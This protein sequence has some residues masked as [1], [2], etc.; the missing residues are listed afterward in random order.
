[1]KIEELKI[2]AGRL[3]EHPQDHGWR[4]F[5]RLIKY[6]LDHSC[7]ELNRLLM[8][9]AER[10]P[11]HSPSHLINLLGISLKR[12]RPDA[13]VEINQSPSQKVRLQAL[14]RLLREHAED[15]TQIVVERHNSF[16]AARRFLVPQVIL[17]SYFAQH[18]VSDL[19]FVDFGTGLGIM[20]RQLNSE[21]LYRAFSAD[22]SWPEGVPRFREIPL[23]RAMGVDCGPMPD[24]EWV[25]ACYGASTYY[26]DLFDELMFTLEVL[27]EDHAPVEYREIDLLNTEALSRFLREHPIHAGNLSYVLYEIDPEH[28]E[29]VL[30][31]LREGLRAP[32]LII[33]TEPHAE[34]TQQGC[35]VMAY[36]HDRTSPYRL[37]AVSDGHFKGEV[38]AL[39]DYA[40]FTARYPIL[41]A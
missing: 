34:L 35:Y 3:G 19:G 37:C 23:R 33:V 16:T 39:Q 26:A 20:P 28:R 41:F 6:A 12:I 38:T 8:E 18:H 24:L 15:V 29:H 1:M 4:E 30:G 36:S 9:C 32:G 2:A 31:T 22:L 7:P 25:R 5:F 13:L 17:S 10:Q 40:E 14:R 27:A 21:K 11:G